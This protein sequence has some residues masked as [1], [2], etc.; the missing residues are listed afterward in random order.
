[1]FKRLKK[2]LKDAGL[3]AYIV[4][5]PLLLTTL[6]GLL[7]F[8]SSNFI[9]DKVY[10]A[11]AAHKRMLANVRNFVKDNDDE[12]VCAFNLKMVSTLKPI[13]KGEIL[14][15]KSI[16]EVPI[17][18]LSLP[19]QLSLKS[20]EVKERVAARNIGGN[21]LITEDDLLS[22]TASRKIN[23]LY[24]SNPSFLYEKNRT[25]LMEQNFAARIAFLT[26]TLI[27]G[28]TAIATFLI[29][30]SLII[31]QAFKT[32]L[33][34]GFACVFVPLVVS[35]FDFMHWQKIRR[36]FNISV[37]CCCLIGVLIGALAPT[38]VQANSLS[39]AIISEMEKDLD[40]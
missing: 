1:M 14:K 23:P 15:D 25:S 37:V 28:G 30:Q 26:I 33:F 22:E 12:A 7:A 29:S 24:Q 32:N 27:F 13:A 17:D 16:E 8:S 6:T 4:L 18:G 38:K 5:G 39:T 34:L 36:P 9:N 19:P 31:K 11:D 3:L 10:P 20:E 35:V 21:C 2:I 40:P